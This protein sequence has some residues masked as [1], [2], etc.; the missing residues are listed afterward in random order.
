MS[1][2]KHLLNTGM[3]PTGCQPVAGE[4][5]TIVVVGVARGGTSIVS[6]AMAHLG[7]FMGKA[8]EPVYEDVALSLAMESGD[9][10]KFCEIARAYDEMHQVWAWKRPSVINHLD[11]IKDKLRNPY[12]I[13]VFRD[14][15][16]I[17]NRNSISMGLGIIDGMEKALN[18]YK[19]VLEF[20]RKHDPSGMIVSSEK[21]VNNKSAFLKELATICDLSET[22]FQ[23]KFTQAS[24][25]I[26]PN[27]ENYLKETHIRDSLGVLDRVTKK[28]VSGWACLKDVKD[29]VSLMIKVNNKTVGK[30]IANNMREDVRLHGLHPTG[31]CGFRFD[32]ENDMTL[33]KGD[34]VSVIFEEGLQD[35]KKSPSVF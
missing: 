9:N 22:Q 16:S 15:F 11:D 18:E 12:F 29:P 28:F 32:F 3:Q 31:L 19:K 7:V 8:R 25:F 5:R 14:V 4:P 17:A 30:I 20:I 35:L 1:E 6:G 33:K 34:E 23:R 2:L 13:F 26:T 27:P 10:E 21:I 24:S